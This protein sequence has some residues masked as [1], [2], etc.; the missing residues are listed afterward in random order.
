MDP[1][2]DVLNPVQREAVQAGEGPVLVLA[3]PGSGKTRVLTH[4]VGYLVGRLGI[5][6]FRI[7]AVTFTNKA[8]LEMKARLQDLIG[9]ADL[10]QLTIGTFH[11]T[12]ATILR[13][14]GAALGID[15]RFLIYDQSDQE[16]LVKRALA[17]LN[18][19]DK[20]FR[21][22]S[23]LSAISSAKSELQGPAD[24]RPA[25]YR[26][27][28]VS[29]VYARYQV[30]LH[31]N[32]ALDFDDLLFEV[33]HLFK[34]NPDVLQKYRRRYRSVL[35]DEFQDTNMAQYEIVRLLAQEA[36][37]VFVVGDEDQSIYSWRGADFRNVRRFQ[38]DFPECEL[39]LLEQN[40]RSTQTILRAAQGIIGRNVQRTDKRLWTENPAGLPVALFEAYDEREEA[41]FV[42]DE[43]QRLVSRG[44]CRAADCAVMYRT[45]AQSRVLEDEFVRR[46]VPYRIVGATRFY[47]RREIKDVLA[48]LRLVYSPEDSASFARIVNVPPRG[49]G[50]KT[51]ATFQMWADELGLSWH[52]ALRQLAEDDDA[53]LDGRSR[54]AL[55]GFHEM[56]EDL[57][58]RSREADLLD[59][60]DDVLA[61][62]GY[63]DMVRDGTEEGTERWQNIQELRTVARDYA[64]LLPGE[65]LAG[66]LTN[67]S[68]VSDVDTL[69]EEADAAT[70]LTLHA[71][72]GLEFATVLLVGMEEGL[73]PHSRS[74]DDP[75]QMEEERRLCYVGLTRAKQRLYLTHT[76]RRTIY[77]YQELS[78]PSRFLHDIPPDLMRRPGSHEPARPTTLRERPVAPRVG[79]TR[80]RLAGERGAVRRQGG[81]SLPAG[82]YQGAKDERADQSPP[83]VQQFNAGDRVSHPSF[84]KGT[85][86]ASVV[87]DDDEEEVTVAFEGRGI[88][89]LLAS[90]ARMEKKA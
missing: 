29:R 53:P 26:Q 45:N 7:M 8:A 74:Q 52:Q 11:A 84:G 44:E 83:A 86:I 75:D 1:L 18:I 90:Y 67:V 21:A 87:K 50:R 88:K 62:T 70:L 28:I 65:G 63:V 30:L 14:D 9:T 60:F 31:D 79:L 57:R 25:N 38:Q 54:Q 56:M 77:G 51:L 12:C 81:R 72:K 19:D 2:L 80:A 40:Y 34:E 59:L 15:N 6:P 22:S 66:F 76:F 23:V 39:I 20:Q 33:V 10:R 55:L 68:L 27:E 43:I 13:R 46:G 17:D 36:R 47:G 41:Q 73:F 48:Y 37:H 16:S 82:S 49:I 69:R 61:R 78:E 35:V 89:R 5:Q 58:S 24:L 85:V 3:G 71:A 4:R 64:G 32:N 42:V